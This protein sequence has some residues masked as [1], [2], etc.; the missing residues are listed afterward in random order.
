MTPSKILFYFCLS[1]I[2][3]IF[4][5]SLIFIPQLYLSGLLFLGVFAISVSFLKGNKIIIVISFC[6]IF[7][8]FGVWRYQ[9][10]NI[11]LK[12]SG[13]RQ[14]NDKEIILAGKILTEPDV[15]ENTVQLVISTEKILIKNEVFPVSGKVLIKTNKYPGYNYADVILIKGLLKTPQQFEGFDYKDYLAKKGIFSLIDWP[16]IELFAK[17]DYSNF[18]QFSYGQ[19]LKFKNKIRENINQN[20]SFT[21]SKLLSGILLGDQAS[22][23][24]E[25]KEK[26][27]TTGLRHI[28]AISGMNVAII[29]SVLMSLFLGI[30]LWRNQAFYLTV[31]F[32]FLFVAMIG[33]QPSVVR[34]G[35][36]GAIML[37]AQKFG[38]LSTSTRAI[39][40][41]ATIMLLLNPMLLRWNIGFQLSF[42][43][44][45][46]IVLLSKPIESFL[47]FIPQEKFINLRSIISATLSAQIFTLPIL[48]YNFGQIS[49][50]A[51]ITNILVVP[52]VD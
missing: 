8:L 2:A 39:V 10:A 21:E 31:I 7:V 1:L 20:F 16:E 17:E 23:S 11:R 46:G 6:L 35:I 4:V 15:R 25:F 37:L 19:I 24:E 14:Y 3:G 43:A 36:M 26:L 29:C 34:A 22:F 28:T 42:L 13:L 9:I 32:I 50:I 40:I 27:N 12:D 44:I 41:T 18:W 33:F 30:G 38:R 5:G 52:I 47:K 49:L 48:I 51:P 45:L